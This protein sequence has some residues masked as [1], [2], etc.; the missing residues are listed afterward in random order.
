MVSSCSAKRNGYFRINLPRFPRAYGECPCTAVL[1]Q[2]TDMPDDVILRA[3]AREAIQSGTLPATKPSRTW[4]GPGSRTPCALCREPVRPSQ[5]EMEIEYRRDGATRGLDNYHLHL[6][7]FA[8]WECE[9]ESG[10][11]DS[12]RLRQ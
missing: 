10:G 3:N 1:L 8:A 9:R 7:C 12:I 11:Y 4:G 5:M 2:P 6:R